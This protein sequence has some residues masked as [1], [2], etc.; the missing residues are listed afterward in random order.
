MIKDNDC[1]KCLSAVYHLYQIKSQLS[2]SS[3]TNTAMIIVY[4]VLLAPLIGFGLLHFSGLYWTV[5]P[6]FYV[7]VV[8]YAVCFV[9]FAL[10]IYEQYQFYKL[11]HLIDDNRLYIKKYYQDFDI[12]D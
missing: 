6:M 10:V 1:D 3:H 2:Y 4:L 5:T 11:I 9:F 12:I 8:G 7:G